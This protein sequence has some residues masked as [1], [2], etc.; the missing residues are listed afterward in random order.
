LPSSPSPQQ[1]AATA[2]DAKSVVTSFQN[3]KKATDSK[4]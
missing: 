3:L 1:L 2:A 4:C